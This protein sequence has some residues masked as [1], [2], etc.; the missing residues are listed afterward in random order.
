MCAH[1]YNVRKWRPTQQTATALCAKNAGGDY[2]RGG[3]YLRDTTVVRKSY[4]TFRMW[5]AA[6][7]LNYSITNIHNDVRQII[8]HENSHLTH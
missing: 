1:V 6:I 8:I 4:S 3:A 7:V 5:R 2:A